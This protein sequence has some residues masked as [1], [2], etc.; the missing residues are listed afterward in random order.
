MQRTGSAARTAHD[1]DVVRFHDW[2]RRLQRWDLLAQ[3]GPALAARAWLKAPLREARRAYRA[4][5][6]YGAA[7]HADSG[8]SPRVQFAHLLW[9]ALRHGTN[10]DTFYRFALYRDRR[11]RR[12]QRYV[13]GTE[14]A[15]L[16]R[17]IAAG[18]DTAAAETLADKRR[19][20][21]W[22]ERHGIPTVPILLELDGGRVVRGAAGGAGGLP[23]TDLFAKPAAAY[24][25]AGVARWRRVAP[26]S[27]EGAGRR[28]TEAEVLADLLARSRSSPVV[29]QECQ[30]NHSAL[31]GVAPCALGTVRAL[32][33]RAPGE[34]P[35]FLVGIFRTGTGGAVADNLALGG[36]ISLVD[37][38]TGVL[39]PGMRIDDALR[40]VPVPAHP[41]TGVRFA[42]VR[43][44]HWPELVALT[45][46]AHAQLGD[47]PCIGWDAAMLEDGPVLVEGNW[48]PDAKGAQMPL[49]Y[50]LCDTDYL[51]CMNAHLDR[52]RHHD[53][54]TLV[55]LVRWEPGAS[56][57]HGQGREAAASPAAGAR[58]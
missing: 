45:L 32:T 3:G 8:V 41:D 54:A 14:A 31:A 36:V 7:A 24:G 47:L 22:C 17:L 1:R 51:R 34:P 28:W 39:Q 37:T 21:A 50:G 20:A 44:P 58:G 38:A 43:L 6:R 52:L 11:W 53:P 48:N 27:Y 19:F 12:A 49:D 57:R 25:G 13:E 30:R 56:P 55:R 26:G 16:Y 35:Q 23:P 40:T 15:W 10:A 2:Y 29:V 4:V 33:I 46:R 18:G 42:G 5:G 9:L